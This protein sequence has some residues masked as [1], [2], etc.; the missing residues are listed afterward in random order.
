MS[1][2][3]LEVVGKAIESGASD[4]IL[5]TGSPPALKLTGRVVFQGSDALS[6]ENM[7]GILQTVA[8]ARSL[9]ALHESGDADFAWQSPAGIRFRVNAFRQCG[10]ASLVMRRVSSSVPSFV[11]LHL[12]EGPLE[13]LAGLSRGLVFVT[14]VTGSGKSTTLASIVEHVNTHRDDH[15]IT[16]EDPVEYRFSDRRCLIQQ[17]E[18]G[19]DTQ[20]WITGLRS[21][22]RE[23][24]DVVLIGEIRDQETMEAALAAA[25]T[26]HLVLSS[27]HTLNAIQTVERALT[28]FPPS[29]HQLV[30]YML[31]TLLEGVV[32][33]RLLPNASGSGMVPAVE[34]LLGTPRVRE[35]LRNGQS[36]DLEQAIEEG[37]GHYG[38]CSFNQSLRSL[39]EADLISIEDALRASDRPDD[40]KLALRGVVRGTDRGV[41]QRPASREERRVP[42]RPTS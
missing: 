18:I 10:E 24:P 7:A 6:P 17:R 2:D 33:Q 42:I 22:M 5:K 12:P 39:L 38:T 34:I 15:V 31:S 23:A 11:D 40:L 1:I 8:P 13:K 9:E 29:Q 21:A 32:S 20:S 30:R 36:A 41:S 16:L 4:V 25:E 35:L 27:L 19:M 3:F 37:A 26:G 14:G 28:F